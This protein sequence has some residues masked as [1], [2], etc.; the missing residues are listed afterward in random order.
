LART[1]LQRF[2]VADPAAVSVFVPT[3]ANG[4]DQLGTQW[5]QPD[6]V[7]T[8]A[9]IPGQTGVGFETTPASFAPL[10]RLDVL[11]QMFGQSSSIYMRVPFQVNDAQSLIQLTLG[12]RFDD[13][14]VAY[15]NGVF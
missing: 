14:F 3:T 15:L 10:I 8:T 9:W 7:E 5:T 11:V 2:D 4:G 12:M 1:G 6:F 13:G